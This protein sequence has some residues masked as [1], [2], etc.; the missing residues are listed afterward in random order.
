VWSPVKILAR[1]RQRSFDIHPDGERIVAA[2][3]PE[4][5]SDN[6]KDKLVF[7]FN[8]FDELHRVAPSR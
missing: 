4:S 2:V 7:I 3:A 5:E 6:R 8:F 1:I